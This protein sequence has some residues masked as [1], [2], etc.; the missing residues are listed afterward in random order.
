MKNYHERMCELAL[1]ELATDVSGDGVGNTTYTFQESGAT[2]LLT[3]NP[4][5]FDVSVAVHV[6][7]Q[8]TPIGRASLIDCDGI[9]A[10]NDK[11]GKYLEFIG[12][13]SLAEGRYGD[14]R[15]TAGFRMHLAPEVCLELFLLLDKT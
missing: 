8:S 4:Y 1:L 13:Q 2:I 9:K 10:V 5:D 12:K 14:G 7:G 3:Y 15:K 11:R 6:Q